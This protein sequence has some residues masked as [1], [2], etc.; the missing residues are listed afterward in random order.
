MLNGQKLVMLTDAQYMRRQQ[1]N[2]V[3]DYKLDVSPAAV[4][5]SLEAQ[6]EMV[7]AGVGMAVMPGGIVPVRPYGII[8]DQ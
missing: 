2:L 6:I 8:P 3:L 7:K 5:K 1:D 4:V